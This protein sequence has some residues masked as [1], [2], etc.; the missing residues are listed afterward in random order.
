MWDLSKYRTHRMQ[1]ILF[2]HFNSFIVNF[3]NTF[4]HKRLVEDIC[5][6]N[7][8]QND[9]KFDTLGGDNKSAAVMAAKGV[10]FR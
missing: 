6:I 4:P 9:T 8:A 7:M 5:H 10:W 2:S 3:I 1:R